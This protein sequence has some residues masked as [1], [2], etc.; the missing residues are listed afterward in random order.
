MASTSARI[1]SDKTLRV[2]RLRSAFAAARRTGRRALVVYWPVGVP[3]PA[4]TVEVLGHLAEAGADVLEVGVPFSDPLADGPILQRAAQRALAAGTRWRDVLAAIRELRRVS[5]VPVVLFSYLNP[6]WRRGL[7]TALEAA[8]EAGADGVLL[9]D[10][11]VGVDPELDRLLTRAPLARVPLWAPTTAPER[12][13]LVAE[14]AEGFLYCLSRTG[15]TG[16]H[17][18]PEALTTDLAELRRMTSAPLA[19]GFGIARPDEAADVARRADGIVVGSAVVEAWERGGV[20]EAVAL[21]R[22]LRD[23]L[24]ID[25]P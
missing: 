15:V 25:E 17:A 3:D 20:A 1:S 6:L 24:Q 22:S 21:V 23:A 2:E 18:G 5:P 11:P 7:A 19:V 9:V 12:R 14:A 4:T 8:A 10:A 13:A 16:T